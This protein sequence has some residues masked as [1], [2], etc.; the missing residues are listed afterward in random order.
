M[1]ARDS[2]DVSLAPGDQE[3]MGMAVVSQALEAPARTIL[4]NARISN[5]GIIL[6]KLSRQ[7]EGTVFDVVSSTFGSAYEFGILDPLQV[8]CVALETAV[9]GAILALSVGTLILKSRP[10]LTYEP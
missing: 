5:P 1:R 3:R 7:P 9:S 10:V 6:D 4:A 8:A 2:I